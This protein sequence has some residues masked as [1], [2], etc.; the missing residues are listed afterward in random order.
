MQ[1]LSARI[2]GPPP[3]RS[4]I[5][6]T[7]NVGILRRLWGPFR[8]DVRP[9]LDDTLVPTEVNPVADALGR[10]FGSWVIRASPG[11]GKRGC[12]ALPAAISVPPAD[13]PQIC[14]R[15]TAV[16]AQP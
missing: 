15:H 11:V 5:T 13:D 6:Y 16:A 14:L 3:S 12:R 1:G 7:E 9:Q 2:R 4:S 10:K 8:P